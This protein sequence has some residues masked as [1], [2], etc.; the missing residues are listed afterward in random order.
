M[1]SFNLK[2]LILTG[3]LGAATLG[4]GQSLPDAP[5]PQNVPDAPSATRP[6][7]GLPPASATP[8]PAA[9]GSQTDPQNSTQTQQ[10]DAPT[11]KPEVKTVPAGGE[12]QVPTSGRDEIGTFVKNVNFVTV[13]VT[14][15]DP[16]GRPVFGLTKGNFSVYE[17]GKRQPLSFFTSD[18]FPISAAIVIDVGMPEVALRK[19]EETY[20][21]LAGAFSEFDE[22]SV[23]SYGNTVKQ[24]QD[25]AAA[26][27]DR[28][29]ATL[30]RVKN[31]EGKTGGTLVTGGPMVSGPTVNGR[32]FDPGQNHPVPNVRTMEPS[33]VLNDA[34]LRAAM[35]LG[36]RDRSRRKVIFVISDGRE[37][38]SIASYTDVLKVL[39]SNE[40]AV[41]GVA[42][43]SAAIPGYGKLGKIRLPRQ[44]YGNILP[45][46]A[47]AT[48]GEVFTS[49]DKDA[50]E[51][52]Y[53]R[54][55]ETARNQYTLGYTSP[56]TLSTAY[57][58][59]EVTVDR[60]GLQVFAR[61]GYYPL[62]PSRK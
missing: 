41:Y 8:R 32:P 44:G 49:L 45:K 56:A 16:D 43:D 24:Q 25:F 10:P 61:D 59:I 42:V 4:F 1:R 38:G 50:V 23:Y 3:I 40:V 19:I 22:L 21:A 28:T 39:L 20:S 26:L 60:S 13:P 31:L 51:R 12:T 53:A 55:M 11:P 58:S 27:G 17:D 14:V 47:S 62:P 30:K 36:K 6:I 54:L 37:D 2:F 29:T 7:P 34:I 5:K 18:P 33:R 48:G 46:Y 57:R 35:D 9:P 15:K 52:A